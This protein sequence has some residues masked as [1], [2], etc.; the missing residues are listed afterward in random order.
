MSHRLGLEPYLLQVAGQQVIASS[1]KKT[2]STYAEG[3]WGYKVDVADIADVER[4]LTELVDRLY[5]SKQLI[6]EISESGGRVLVFLNLPSPGIDS[7][8]EAGPDTLKKLADMGIRFG[9]EIFR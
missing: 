6:C 1:G 5:A 4:R 7:S 2:R 3:K 8:F 9:F